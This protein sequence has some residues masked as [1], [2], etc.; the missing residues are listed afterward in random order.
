MRQVAHCVQV[1][2]AGA[3][4]ESVKGAKDRID[5]WRIGGIFLE[6]E[7]ALL[8][9]LQQLH[10][11][12]VEFAQ[13]C[14]ILGKVEANGWL[15]GLGCVVRPVRPAHP[16]GQ[17]GMALPVCQ[18]SKTEVI[19]VCHWLKLRMVSSVNLPGPSNVW[20]SHARATF[21]PAVKKGGTSLSGNSSRSMTNLLI[22]RIPAS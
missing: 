18:A 21:K 13:K 17:A 12:S 7:D 9:I 6:H 2:E 5:C 16:S 3:A 4:L 11:L 20:S 22:G 8:N 14:Q 10:G 15:V 19:H 1:Q